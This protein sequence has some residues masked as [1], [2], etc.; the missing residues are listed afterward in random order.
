MEWMG[1]LFNGFFSDIYQLAVQFAAWISIKL[2]IQWVEFKI[3][4]LTFSWDVAKQIL[5]NLQF[6]DLISASFNNLPA[7]M[8]GILLY[9]RLDKGI[10][11]ITQAFI[12][13]FLLNMFGW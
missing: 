2:A 8:K 4:L 3:F 13:R 6:S 1:D 10:S 11:I 5:I 7:E 12:A 9:L